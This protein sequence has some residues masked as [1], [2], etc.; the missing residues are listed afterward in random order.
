VSHAASNW[1]WDQQIKN[2]RHKLLLVKL[3][4]SANDDGICW[5]SLR[6]LSR[7]TGISKSTLGR[8]ARALEAGG[9]LRIQETTKADGSKGVNVYHLAVEGVPPK[10]DGGVSQNQG[11]GVP[12]GR[13][14]TVSEPPSKDLNPH[15]AVAA[16]APEHIDGH[17]WMVTSTREGKGPFIA[18]VAA[19]TCTCENKHPTE[20]RHLRAA[21]VADEKR[22]KA[23]MRG[24]RDAVWDGLVAAFGPPAEKQQKAYG[25][26]TSTILELILAA[27]GT[28]QTPER[29]RQEVD[30]R[31]AALVREWGVGKVTL[32]AFGTNW[33][34]AGKL[35]TGAKVADKTAPVA[36]FSEY[37]G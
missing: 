30:A 16:R 14:R 35:L 26:V 15:A 11:V 4:D 29:M 34:L 20:C 3:A 33:T 5:P 28:E 37:D 2:P 17:R 1:A 24:L 36:R 13:D 7:H 12:P 8:A 18:D 22:E 6:T 9:L 31:Y 23:V 19:G 32:Q 25:G 27:D 10:R 21:A